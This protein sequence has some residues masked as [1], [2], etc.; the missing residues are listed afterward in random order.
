MCYSTNSSLHRDN[1]FINTQ[2]FQ[3]LLNHNSNSRIAGGESDLVRWMYDK[4]YIY[5][6]YEMGKDHMI[7][8]FSQ[9]RS[10][11]SEFAQVF[12]KYSMFTW[13]FS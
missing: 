5:L 6:N 4:K 8:F 9:F 11:R 12:G 1:K 3:I 13:P 7:T 2:A 10:N